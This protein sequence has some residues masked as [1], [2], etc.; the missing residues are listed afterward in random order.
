MYRLLTKCRKMEARE[1]LVVIKD[2]FFEG[3]SIGQAKAH[4][5]IVYE[6]SAPTTFCARVSERVY[7]QYG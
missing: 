4:F 5:S 6:G 2:W 7:G 1:F 3:L